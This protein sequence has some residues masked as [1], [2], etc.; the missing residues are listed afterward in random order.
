MTFKYL[1]IFLTF[2]AF[3]TSCSTTNSKSFVRPEGR[4][5]FGGAGTDRR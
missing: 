5:F 2:S 3:F 1:I 4:E